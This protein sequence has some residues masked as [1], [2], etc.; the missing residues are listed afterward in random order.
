MKFV[1]TFA[2]TIAKLYIIYMKNT[3]IAIS[4]LAI[5]AVGTGVQ[6]QN[7]QD[8][9]ALKAELKMY[10]KMK[11]IQIKQMKQNYEAKL[12]EMETINNNLKLSQEREDSIQ[13]LYNASATR[14]KLMDA[15]LT[16][17][18]QQAAAASS[19]SMAVMPGYSFRIQIGSYRNF[20]I[21]AKATPGSNF[22]AEKSPEGL[23]RYTIGQF[24]TFEEADAFKADVIKMGIKDAIVVGYKDGQRISV[25]EARERTK[26]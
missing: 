16:S 8:K 13:R 11:P 14:L 3:I 18:K 24:R 19:N 17:V 5:L 10:K 12:A 1:I 25:T 22:N 7:A 26:K 20:D 23:N 21:S 15:E 4:T 9:K 2:P 6:A